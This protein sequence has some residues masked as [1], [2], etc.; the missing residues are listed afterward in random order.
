[1]KPEAKPVA[2]DFG[3]PV[4]EPEQ[5]A[6]DGGR[7]S[8]LFYQLQVLRQEVLELRGITQE[9]GYLLKRMARDQ[10]EQYI[11]L[12]ARLIAQREGSPTP[13]VSVNAGAF[14]L[15]TTQTE[16]PATERDAYTAAF[17]LMKDR[18]FEDSAEAFDQLIV[19]Y[20]NGQFTPNAFYWLGELYLTNSETEKARQSFVQVVNLYPDHQKVP[21]AL[22]KLGVVY[23]RLGETQESL[24]YLD[25]VLSEH[26]LSSAAGL[27]QSYASELQ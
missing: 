1:M 27:A 2:S 8:E 10:K 19:D 3:A 26:P 25:R 20:P 5:S 12:D 16:E 21:D 6:G 14:D 7:L 9:Q 17:N 23:H 18:Q 4:I 22:Y 11:D 15:P 24:Q 13:A